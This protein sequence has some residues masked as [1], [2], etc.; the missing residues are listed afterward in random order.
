MMTDTQTA[1]AA[2]IQLKDEFLDLLE[3]TFQGQVQNGTDQF[4][5]LQLVFMAGATAAAQLR[6][7]QLE[8][9]IHAYISEMGAQLW[10]KA[11][12]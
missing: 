8:A 10:G 12:A 1:T 11:E 5:T 3:H 6:P 7:F 2:D 4:R 9:Q